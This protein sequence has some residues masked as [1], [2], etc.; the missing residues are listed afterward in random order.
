MAFR[1]PHVG[2]EPDEGRVAEA[3]LV[4]DRLARHARME[5]RAV[6]A[7]RDRHHALGRDARADHDR[8]HA[9]TTGDDPV[10]EPVDEGAPSAD[11]DRDVPAAHHRP[12]ERLRGDAPEPAV[13]GA[14]GVDETHAAR[15]DE[16]AQA[17]DGADV[18]RAP[19]PDGLDRNGRGPRLGE[20]GAVGLA[21]GERPPAVADQPA[22]LREGADL[23][24][25][26]SARGLGVQDCVHG[27]KLPVRAPAP[28][29]NDTPEREAIDT[30][31]APWAEASQRWKRRASVSWAT[32]DRRRRRGTRR[33][34][35]RRRRSHHDR[36][37]RRAGRRRRLPLGPSPSRPGWCGR[38]G[39][40]R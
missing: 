26:V 36:R 2:D 12:A 21:G 35:R 29:G 6:D 40:C 4:A 27:G 28:R 18:C 32:S 24:A 20:E 3:E 15:P 33:D 10:R 13:H 1:A 9:L 11:G 31:V 22:C 23:L 37:R 38:R 19:H 30:E 16:P 34:R 7:G 25:A 5:P 14:M 17:D 39:S 8:A